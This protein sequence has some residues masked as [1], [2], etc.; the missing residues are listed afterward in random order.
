MNERALPSGTLTFLLTD[1]EGSTRLWQEHP[2]VMNAVIERHDRLI[3]DARG[4]GAA[5]AP[6]ED[7][8]AIVRHMD[9]LHKKVAVQLLFED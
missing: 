9:P 7:H 2:S 8:A 4:Y 3:E 1:I 6:L 5:G